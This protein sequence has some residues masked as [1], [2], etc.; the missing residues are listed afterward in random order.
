[1]TLSLVTHLPLG[2]QEPSLL[3]LSNAAS[4]GWRET[5]TSTQQPAAGR[6]RRKSHHPLFCICTAERN[7]SPKPHR[8]PE[9]VSRRPATIPLVSPES[10]HYSRV[11]PLQG[12]LKTVLV[13]MLG[14]RAPY[15]HHCS[16]PWGG[17]GRLH[18][19]SPPRNVDASMRLRQKK[20]LSLPAEQRASLIWKL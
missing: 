1:M 3:L 13:P 18:G 17:P 12:T 9:A 2:L 19:K 7:T 4:H 20:T 6:R 16:A 15:T 5:E 10:L 14:C 8:Y 11:G